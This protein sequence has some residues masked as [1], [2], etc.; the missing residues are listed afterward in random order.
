MVPIIHKTC[1]GQAAWYLDDE[2]KG[3]DLLRSD[4]YLRMNGTHPRAGDMFNETCDNCGRRIA[5]P[6]DLRTGQIK[7]PR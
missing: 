7:K 2:L 6:H 1:G 4:Y 5:G 3:G